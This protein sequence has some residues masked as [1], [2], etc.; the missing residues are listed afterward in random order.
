MVQVVS[1]DD[2]VPISLER[3]PSFGY[4]QGLIGLKL[5][6]IRESEAQLERIEDAKP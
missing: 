4:N 3:L 1:D 5:V 2:L 6:Y